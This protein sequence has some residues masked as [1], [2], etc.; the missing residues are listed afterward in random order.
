MWCSIWKC[1]PALGGSCCSWSQTL[2]SLHIQCNRFMGDFF[3]E[4]PLFLEQPPFWEQPPFCHFESSHHTH[5]QCPDF[6]GAFRDH[7]WLGGRWW[8]LP[9]GFDQSRHWSLFGEAVNV[10]GHWFVFLEAFQDRSGLLIFC[11]VV[12]LVPGPN[13][14]FRLI[15]IAH[16]AWNL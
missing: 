7:G 2:N 14:R 8:F 4:Q 10:S 9:L 13:Y 11:E 1:N 15:T 6:M 5:T 12:N 3:L 16:F